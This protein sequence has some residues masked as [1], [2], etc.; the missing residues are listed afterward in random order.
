[1]DNFHFDGLPADIHSC[2]TQRQDDW[3]VW[4]CAQCAGYERRLN[5]VTGEMQVRR[6]GS[7]AQHTGASDKAAQLE[8]FAQ[9]LSY[10]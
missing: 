1:M 6:G 5:L 9:T 3:I 2:T 4:R 8:A 7:T 10:N